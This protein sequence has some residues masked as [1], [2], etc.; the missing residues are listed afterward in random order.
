MIDLG[1][2]LPRVRRAAV[3]GLAR[4]GRA[5]VAALAERGVLVTG[6]DARPEPEAGPL[7]AG[8]L[9]RY[10]LGGHP[11]GILDGADLVVVSPGVPLGID[12]LRTAA[13]RGIPVIAEIELAA[14]LLAGPVVGITG[15]NGK[16]TTTSLA[17]AL[18]RAA[19]RAAVA[20]GNLGTPWVEYATA[21]RAAERAAAPVWVVELSS[22][23]LEATRAFAP[24]VAVHLNLTPDHLDRHGSLAA[25]A[26]AK[27]RIFA[28]QHPGQ[29]AVLNADDPAVRVLP[30]RARRAS[31]S[32]ETVPEAGTWLRDGAFWSNQ[33]GAAERFAGRAD[34]TLAGTHN[35]EN[36]LAALAATVPLGVTPESAVRA[37]REFVP[38]P[39][40]MALVRTLRGVAYYDDSKGTNVDATLKSLEGFRDGSVLLV[41][42]G[43]RKNDDF[44]RLAPLV[45]RKARLVLAIGATAQEILAALDGV[46]P[47][48]LAGTLETAVRRASGEAAAGDVVLLS[49]ACASF[50]Q[51][52]NFEHRGEVFEQLVRALPEGLAVAPEGTSP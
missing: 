20:C 6:T 39:H 15:T 44:R 46:V 33:R 17:A 14:R 28:H 45:G 29:L 7:P 10:E 9:V 41:L 19:G 34:L 25:Y 26:A 27:A 30:T 32:R 5:A 23:Q 47:V 36:A 37:F 49:P 4:S 40:R 22:F 42:G 51:F 24:D 35:E 16:S 8:P 3:F 38:L 18:L 31:F 43:K 52:R 11:P 21:A 50:D 48:V 2:D 12:A 13:A 1:A